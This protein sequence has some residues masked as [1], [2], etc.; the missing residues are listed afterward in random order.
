MIR[1]LIKSSRPIYVGE[2]IFRHNFSGGFQIRVSSDICGRLQSCLF[3]QFSTSIKPANVHPEGFS[4]THSILLSKLEIA[5]KNHQ[6]AEAWE[7]FT[8]IRSLHGFPNNSLIS[9]LIIQLSYSSDPHWLRKAYDLVLLILKNK[10]HLLHY[11]FLTKLALSLARAQMP[12]PASTVLRLMLETQKY[13]P[14]DLWKTVFL[15]MVKS[16][17]GTYLASDI[18]IEICDCYLLHMK[19]Y[20]AKNSKH[21]KLISPDTMIFN[22]VLNACLQFRSTLKAECIVELMPLAGV[23]ADA[24]TIVIIARMHEMNGRRD[25]LKKFRVHI[26]RVSALLL[27][28]YRQFYDSLLSLHFKFDDIDAAAGLVF[29]MY[30]QKESFLCSGGI[31]QE[32]RRLPQRPLQVMVGSPNLKTSLRL[33]IEPELLQKDYVLDVERQPDLVMFIDGKFVPSN[34]ALAKLINGYKR[35]GKVGELSKLLVSIH[36]ELGVSGEV[37][38]SRDL[39]K[40]CI[41]LGWLETVHDIMEDME[42]AGS[43]MGVTTYLSLLRAYCK[44]NLLEDA[45]VLLKQMRKAG[46]LRNVSNEEVIS[47]C[48]SGKDSTDSVETRSATWDGKSGLVQSLILEMREEEKTVPPVVYEI[49][50]SIYFFCK[51]NMIEDALKTYRRMQGRMVQ[52][53]VQTFYNLVN[54]YSSL[55]MY[56][57]ITILWGDIRRRMDSGDLMANRD[58]HELLL[59]NFIRGGYFERVM[60]IIGYMQKHGMYTD[61]WKYK[62]E[63]LKL[64]KDLYKSLKASDAKTE[65]QRKRLEHVRAFRKWVGFD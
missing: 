12:I 11:D 43:P 50:S 17:I 61:K 22:L 15:H 48:L 40:A 51:G 9:R 18:L 41:Q 52:P 44:K 27:R 65:A 35:N 49:D 60:E 29:D 63:F 34:K 59:W 56:R 14:M 31:I 30:R 6:V 20:G 7:T 26:D 8:D 5:L 24:T 39:M 36:K 62:R 16:E 13:P 47:T 55:R 54:G 37:C 33:Q 42:L 19:D 3:F 58:L 10:P 25:E 46:M 64:H 1:R 21:L 23:V 45:K 2:A 4:S 53:T 57:E 28:H 38:L 32:E